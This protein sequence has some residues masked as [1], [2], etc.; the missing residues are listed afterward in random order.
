MLWSD[1]ADEPPEEL[2]AVERMMRR[3]GFVVAF[4]MVL[5]MVL[6]GLGLAKG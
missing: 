1:P 2:R 6:L 4:A 5:A 3:A